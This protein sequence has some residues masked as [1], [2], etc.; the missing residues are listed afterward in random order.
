MPKQFGLVGKWKSCTSVVSDGF[1]APTSLFQQLANLPNV[2]AL[3]EGKR[4]V[5]TF[6]GEKYFHFY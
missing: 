4:I 5:I 6:Y 1:T 3:R 2:Y